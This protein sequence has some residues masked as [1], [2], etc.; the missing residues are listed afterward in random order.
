MPYYTMTNVNRYIFILLLLPFML[1]AQQPTM[2]LSLK[3]AVEMGKEKSLQA[4]V[5]DYQFKST[6]L[7]YRSQWASRLPSFSMSANLPGFNRSIN[8]I[9][10]PDGSVKFVQ[11][12]QTFGSAAINVNQQIMATGGSL[13]ASST[14][15]RFELLGDKGY[16]QF[17]TSPF[18]LGITQ[19]LLRFNS[20][21]FDW[22][23]ARLRNEQNTRNYV[24]R[25]EDLSGQVT[26]RFFD[27]IAA[28]SDLRL[29][30]FNMRVNDTLLKIAR[31][32]YNL[33]KIG[34][35]E[36][37]Q[38][39][40]RLMNA[41]NS[42]DQ[43]KFRLDNSE[44]QLKIFLGI[45]RETVLELMPNTDVPL[46]EPI[47][48][49][50]ITEARKNRSELIGMDIDRRQAEAGLKR[51]SLGRFPNAELSASYGL[52]QSAAKLDKA[53]EHPLGQQRVSLGL[54]IPLLNWGKNRNDYKIARYQL[55][56]KEAELEL[57]LL[58]MEQ[59]VVNQVNQ[60]LQLRKRLLISAKADTIAQRR[61]TIAKSRYLIGKI[62][63][64]NL[65]I[66]Q[67]EKDEA[68]SSY[69]GTLRDFWISYYRLRRITLF[70][71]E[72]NQSLLEA[73]Y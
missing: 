47:L 3:Q 22:R 5:N 40:L 64:T 14:L 49:R 19:P 45:P 6:Q 68:R 12:R 51:S 46:Q 50:C 33:G 4:K 39:E 55:A 67:N 43:A 70:D 72:K 28:L 37:L 41:Q 44:Y 66:A 35:D 25:A 56:A 57:Q 16:T 7:S 29:A 65:N 53:Y 24:E 42:Y 15:N 2:Q 61:Y 13:T 73:L 23:I 31:G 17:Q 20:L 9:T 10:Q 62:D 71:F 1:Q 59:E 34:E 48:E 18:S 11:Q 54:N 38:T 26:Q 30:E 60:Y 32:R 8:N 69:Y 63:I 27:V 52:N 21:K 58:N 36:L